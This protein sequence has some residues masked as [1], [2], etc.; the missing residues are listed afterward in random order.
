MNKETLTIVVN[1]VVALG[2]FGLV[3]FGKASFEQAFAG[4]AFL[5]VP[6]A[7]PAIL[8]RLRAAKEDD[9][10]PKGPSL[11]LPLGVVALACGGLTACS[12]AADAPASSPG[13]PSLTV[14]KCAAQYGAELALCSAA[15]RTLAESQ[16]CEDDLRRVYRRPPR[17]KSDGGAP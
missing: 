5:L 6:S 9:A 1:G 2:L 11:L 8:A 17:L 12:P 13:C 14:D 10:P 3:A 16:A 4:V 7:A 15:S